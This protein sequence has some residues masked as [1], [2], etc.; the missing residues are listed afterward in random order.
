MQGPMLNCNKKFPSLFLK[1]WIANLTG[2]K[3]GDKKDFKKISS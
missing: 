3:I 2:G 1:E